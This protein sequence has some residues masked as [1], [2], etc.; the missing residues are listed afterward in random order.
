MVHTLTGVRFADGVGHCRDHGTTGRNANAHCIR[1]AFVPQSSWP[2]G[3]YASWDSNRTQGNVFATKDAPAAGLSLRVDRSCYSWLVSV[4]SAQVHVQIKLCQCRNMHVHAN[5]TIRMCASTVD[6]DSTSKQGDGHCPCGR[7]HTPTQL[8]IFQIYTY[9]YIYMYISLSL[10][11]SWIESNALSNHSM[12]ILRFCMSAM[13][14]SQSILEKRCVF[15]K[16]VGNVSQRRCVFLKDV[17]NVLERRCVF[18]KD[19]DF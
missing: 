12:R 4:L 15:L 13:R 18:L 7:K 9:I 6:Y 10:T 11:R 14:N 17:G 3:Q 8:H 2:R 1:C 5:I 16:D 19:V